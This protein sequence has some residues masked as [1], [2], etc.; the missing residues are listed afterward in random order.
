MLQNLDEN[1]W[2]DR[3]LKQQ[4]QWD[5]G[6]IT[7]PLKEYFDQIVNKDIKILI[8]GCG[9]AHEAAYLHKMG[10][11]NVF[12][13]DIS[14]IPLKQF[15]SLHPSF[16][17]EHILHVDFFNLQ[18]QFD[19]IVEQTFFCALVPDLRQKYAEKVYEL[20]KP[21]GRLIGLLFD[22]PL[23]TDHP[24]FGGDAQEYEKYFRPLFEFHTFERCY[25]S[26]KPR[27]GRELF[28]NLAK[29]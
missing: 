29:L 14:L 6:E 22:D 9:N 15:R 1:Y 19:L 12:L 18:G 10:F 23:N 20:L 25:N 8:P 24:P 17:E 5:A 28:I 7:A 13:A 16:P 21:G 27:Q 26:V 11:S 4:T 2:S 3:Y